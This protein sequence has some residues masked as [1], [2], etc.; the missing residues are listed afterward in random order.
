MF[1]VRLN[2][3]KV[4]DDFMAP[5]WTPAG[6]K[7]ESLTHDVTKQLASGANTLGTLLDEGWYAGRL[8][9]DQRNDGRVKPEF[10]LQL[11]V[12]HTDGSVSVVTSDASWKSSVDGP[13][14]FSGIY[15][16]EID[17]A[18]RSLSGWDRSGFDDRNWNPVGVRAPSAED[19]L[20]PKRH[21]TTRITKELE[22]VAIT[23]QP[24]KAKPE[25]RWV[26]DKVLHSDFDWTGSFTSSHEMLTQLQSNIQ[27]GLRGNFPDVPTDCPQRDERLSWTGDAQVSAPAAIYNADVHAFFASWLESVRL[28]Q[29]PD[30]AVPNVIPNILIDHCGGP[31]GADAC[32]VIPWEIYVRT[33]DRDI[34]GE[35]FDMMKRWV[36]YYE[37]HAGAGIVDIGGFGDWLQ[38]F[39]AEGGTRGD[40]PNDLLG[41]AYFARSASLTARAA[42]VLGNGTE[43]GSAAFRSQ[44]RDHRRDYKNVLIF[45]SQSELG[46]P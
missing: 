40:T 20:S 39:P 33:G 35:N 30:G 42:R 16:G 41:T 10:L 19:H 38:P 15:D 44:N 9:W 11:E 24:P 28:D 22:T 3:E 23:G 18:R 6:M 8:G 25:P 37:A 1:E 17:D 46:I 43:A 4:G 7:V 12:I 5:G 31:G 2:G 34:L 14:H 45:L 26:T 13:I 36:G 29:H 27:W 32:T 21:R